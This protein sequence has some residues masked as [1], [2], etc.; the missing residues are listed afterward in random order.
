M[1]G[2]AAHLRGLGRPRQFRQRGPAAPQLGQLS[3]RSQMKIWLPLSLRGA[4]RRSNPHRVSPP[5]RRLLRYARNDSRGAP[6]LTLLSAVTAL[7]FCALHMVVPALPLL[8]IAFDDSPARVQ[9]VLTLYLAGIAG[10][11]LIYGPLSDRFGRRPVL[12]AGLAVFLA[13]TLLCGLAGSL[14]ALILGRVLE[15]CGA[16]AGIVLARAIIRDV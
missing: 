5:G 4:Q 13:G 8:V 10:G 6:S 11:Q 1:A 12:I 14:A 3:R 15:A 9:L 2:F 16:C 7:G